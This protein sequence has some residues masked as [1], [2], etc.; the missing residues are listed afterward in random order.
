MRN[1]VNINLFYSILI[2]CEK[3]GEVKPIN[4]ENI[5]IE[6]KKNKLKKC[7]NKPENDV[8]KQGIISNYCVFSHLKYIKLNIF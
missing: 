2:Y 4:N 8:D 1:K 7:A 5:L 3:G 6:L